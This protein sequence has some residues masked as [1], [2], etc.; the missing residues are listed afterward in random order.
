MLGTFLTWLAEQRSRIFVVATC[1]DIE[2][3]PPEL[4]RK[5]RFD[6]IFFVD[7]PDA[8]AR[9][10]IIGIHARRRDIPLTP[11]QAA[12]LAAQSEVFSGAE[13]EQAVVAAL[14]AAHS[15]KCPLDAPLIA[16]ELAATQPLSVVMGEQVAALRAWARD[17]TVPAA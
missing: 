3:L 4:V 2:S 9:A 11:A 10:D 5:G 17:R 1:N 7:L 8:S 16:G 13:L 15:R 12:A 6:E 14:Y